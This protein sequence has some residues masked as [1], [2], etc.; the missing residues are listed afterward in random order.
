VPSLALAL[1]EHRQRTAALIERLDGLTWVAP[2]VASLTEEL[3]SSD[4]R[5]ESLISRMGGS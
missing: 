2:L 3:R 5:L 1:V 4:R